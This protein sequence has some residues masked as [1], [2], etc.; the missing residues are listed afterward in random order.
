MTPARAQL[1]EAA[2][3]VYAFTAAAFHSDHPSIADEPAAL[4]RLAIPVTAAWAGLRLRDA[5]SDPAN[6]APQAAAM[7]VM[8]AL[9]LAFWQ[10]E[11]SGCGSRR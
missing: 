11:C 10:R 1:L 6:R 4:I 5:F 9:G 3:L 2:V 8:A 7:D